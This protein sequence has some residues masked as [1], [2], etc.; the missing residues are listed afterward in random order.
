MG[1]SIGI[2]LRNVNT[3]LARVTDVGFHKN[4]TVRL[5]DITVQVLYGSTGA[6]QGNGEIRGNGGFACAAFAAGH[7]NTYNAGSIRRCFFIPIKTVT[8]APSVRR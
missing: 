8:L 5:F 3:N 7:G 1:A 4:V 2:H 6:A